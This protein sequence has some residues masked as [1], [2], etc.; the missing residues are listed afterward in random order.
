MD[1]L[2]G[3]EVEGVFR[4]VLELCGDRHVAWH[5]LH[6]EMG[7]SCLMCVSV[8]WQRVSCC[9]LRCRPWCS[10]KPRGAAKLQAV[11]VAKLQDIR[12]IAWVLNRDKDILL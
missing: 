10:S 12:S 6:G 9:S 3:L 4:K 8:E 7:L 11:L 2:V 5:S 1:R